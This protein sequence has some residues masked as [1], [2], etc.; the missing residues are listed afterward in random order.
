MSRKATPVLGADR[1]GLDLELTVSGGG[2]Y[3]GRVKSSR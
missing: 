1:F 2:N 3:H